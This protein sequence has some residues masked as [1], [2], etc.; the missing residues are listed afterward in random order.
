M[1]DELVSTITHFDLPNLQ[2]SYSM[3]LSQMV[4]K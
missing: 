3:V 4:L 1:P 2:D